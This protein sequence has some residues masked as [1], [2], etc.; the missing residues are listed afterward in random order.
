MVYRFSSIREVFILSKLPKC[1]TNNI[2]SYLE[3]DKSIYKWKSIFTNE[4]I[5]KLNKGY[6]LTA[7]L[8]II[9]NSQEIIGCPSCYL[10]G[11][12]LNTSFYRCP[13]H[14]KIENFKWIWININDFIFTQKR[15]RN[16]FVLERNK[17]LRLCH[18]EEYQTLQYILRNNTFKN[19]ISKKIIE[20]KLK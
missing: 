16:L 12:L 17:I 2:I 1:V 15:I 20:Y 11:A 8:G 9:E 3:T 6:V 5:P 14:Y 10:N 18:N 13:K 19:Y 4:V 7:Q